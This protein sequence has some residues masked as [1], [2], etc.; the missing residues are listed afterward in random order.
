MACLL[1]EAATQTIKV[2]DW[3]VTSINTRRR[4]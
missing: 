4:H 1:Y 2:I 3:A